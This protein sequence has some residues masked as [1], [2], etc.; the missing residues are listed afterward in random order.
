M[1]EF[2]AGKVGNNILGWGLT[3]ILFVL[4]NPILP[5][6]GA[7]GGAIAGAIGGAVGFGVAGVVKSAWGPKEE[8]GEEESA[9]QA[10]A[11]VPAI[12]EAPAP[13]ETAE[14]TE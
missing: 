10:V 2:F 4:L 13:E 1:K 12:E 6:G 5:I 9:P 14:E 3:I 8:E 7:V 11:E